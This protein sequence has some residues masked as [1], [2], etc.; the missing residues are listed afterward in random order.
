LQTIGEEEYLQRRFSRYPE[1]V[2]TPPA[3]EQD[4]GWSLGAVMRTYLRVTASALTAVPG[5]PRGYQVLTACVHDEPPTQLVLARRLGLDR[6][7]MTHLLDD[8]E[9]AR[10]VERRLDP[11]DR[12]AR[13]IVAT[14]AGLAMLETL[15]RRLAA[16]EDRVLGPLD[17]EERRLLRAL[18][19]KVATAGC[20]PADACTVAREMQEAGQ[21]DGPS[22]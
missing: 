2:T 17:P 9:G 3:V 12:R 7:V 21:L 20:P 19:S 10:L 6:T 11:A 8:L 15:D 22:C 5:G 13:R 18:L 14:E 4:L 1:T 16:V